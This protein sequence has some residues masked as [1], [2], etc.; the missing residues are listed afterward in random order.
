M[1]IQ[2]GERSR[3]CPDGATDGSDAAPPGLWRRFV[4]VAHAFWCRPIAAAPVALFRILTGVVHY[5]QINIQA[6]RDRVFAA[7]ADPRHAPRLTP[8]VAS[9]DELVGEPGAKGSRWKTRFSNGT[10]LFSEFVEVDAPARIVVR[11]RSAP[12]WPRRPW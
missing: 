4:R 1:S 7:I 6:P 11:S 5:D 2:T 9:V 12:R 3:R 10:R 8:A